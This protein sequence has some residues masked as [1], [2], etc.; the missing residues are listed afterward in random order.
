MTEL[1]CLAC[2]EMDVDDDH[3]CAQSQRM[4]KRPLRDARHA[5]TDDWD[6]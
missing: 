6:E 2:G 4:T 5:A 1:L 3:N